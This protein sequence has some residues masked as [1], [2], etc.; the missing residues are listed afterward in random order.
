MAMGNYI[1]SAGYLLIFLASAAFI[2]YGWMMLQ[3]DYARKALDRGEATQAM[4][5]YA[6]VESPFHKV[7][8]LPEL[9]QQEYN[10]LTFN[11]VAILYR[12]RKD[13]EALLK[14]EQLPGHAPALGS[15]GDYS[16][17]MG[18]LLFRQAVQSH[19]PEAS[20]NALKAAMSEYQR[21]LAAEPEDWDLKFNYELVRNIFAQQDRDR[22]SQEQKVK[23]IMEKMRPKEPSYQELVPEKRG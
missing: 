18:N 12:Q 3:F 19:D 6:R 8:W 2:A 11:Q 22:K 23:S 13:E 4:D 1:K 7:P 14:L 21:G 20:V 10:H 5:Y 9:L 17:W 16:F 15:S